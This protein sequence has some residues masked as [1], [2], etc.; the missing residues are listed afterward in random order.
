MPRLKHL[1][2]NYL[3]PFS[4]TTVVSNGTCIYPGFKRGFVELLIIIYLEDIIYI[5]EREVKGSG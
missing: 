5:A 1:N 4:K 3:V 2:R